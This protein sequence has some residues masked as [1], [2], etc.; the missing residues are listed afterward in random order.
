VEGLLSGKLVAY[1]Q[2][3][4]RGAAMSVLIRLLLSEA[5]RQVVDKV[6][7]LS[8]DAVELATGFKEIVPHKHADIL[9]DAMTRGDKEAVR[10]LVNGNP[11]LLEAPLESTL[12]STA[13]LWIVKQKHS[14]TPQKS[15][16]LPDL[17]GMT[18]AERARKPAPI[19]IGLSEINSIGALLIEELNANINTRDMWKQSPLILSAR[20]GLPD[21]ARLMIEKGAKLNN[22]DIYGST[23]LMWASNEG[24]LETVELLLDKGADFGIM[25]ENQ[26]TAL[27]L[28]IKNMHRPQTKSRDYS[29][30][31]M[32]L[33]NKGACDNEA[34]RLAKEYGND[35][36]VKTLKD[37]RKR[38]SESAARQSLYVRLQTRLV[39]NFRRRLDA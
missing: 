20:N 26:E 3:F 9:I 21:L 29:G 28:A 30:I 37:E 39:N 22:V 27:A 16:S 24:H 38:Q 33:I 2:M 14:N 15:G 31:V 19:Q 8:A 17:I 6:K 18:P 10:K 25:N 12:G 36:L 32:R 23:A 35:A 11:E 34:V 1:L 4:F 7:G 13:L 5:V